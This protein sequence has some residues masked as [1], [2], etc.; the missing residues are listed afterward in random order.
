[1]F[2]IALIE[3][4]GSDLPLVLL[5]ELETEATLETG[6]KTISFTGGSGTLVSVGE[7]LRV[8]AAGLGLYGV[9]TDRVINSGTLATSDAAGT[10]TMK[11]PI[12]DEFIDAVAIWT[13]TG[14]L[15]T[16]SGAQADPLNNVALP[17][18]YYRQLN[19]VKDSNETDAIIGILKGLRQMQDLYG[20]DLDEY[21]CIDRVTVRGSRLYFQPNPRDNTTLTLYFYKEPTPFT[22]SD[23]DEITVIPKDFHIRVLVNHV[24]MQYFE[25]KGDTEQEDRFRTK[26]DAYLKEMADS[27][28]YESKQVQETY[29]QSAYF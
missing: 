12:A 5:P 18:T 28:E 7:Q 9:V 2:N 25:I 13:L 20:V 11:D 22:D 8:G 14:F 3:I 6:D 17:S 23:T 19:K 24:C 21:G 1:M 29:R 15:A 4:A 26:F 27:E 16:Q 10:I